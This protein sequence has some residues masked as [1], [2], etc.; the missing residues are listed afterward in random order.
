MTKTNLF[1]NI[2][3]T[4]STFSGSYIVVCLTRFVILLESSMKGTIRPE[5]DLHESGTIGWGKGHQPLYKS[6]TYSGR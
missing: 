2:F 3:T 6:E 1:F 4:Y 5:L